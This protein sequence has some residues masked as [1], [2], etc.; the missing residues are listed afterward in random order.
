[1]S[2]L[3]PPVD[4]KTVTLRRDTGD[5]SICFLDPSSAGKLVTLRSTLKL[6]YEGQA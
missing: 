3:C 5:Y 2:D 4:R 6:Y 1:M